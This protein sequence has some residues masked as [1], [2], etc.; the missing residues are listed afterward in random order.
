MVY[1]IDCSMLFRLELDVCSV[2]HMP[3]L[4]AQ[5]IILYAPG[6]CVVDDCI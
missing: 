3:D 5:G 4:E 6:N 1:T 2:L